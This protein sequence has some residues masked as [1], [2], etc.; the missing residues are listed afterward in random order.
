[1]IVEAWTQRLVHVNEM[2]KVALAEIKKLEKKIDEV[3]ERFIESS[4]T[5]VRKHWNAR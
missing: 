1:M 5:T 4:N 3:V 2:K